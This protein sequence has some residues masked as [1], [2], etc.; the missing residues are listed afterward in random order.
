M[1]NR[2][3]LTDSLIDKLKPETSE[4][5]VYDDQLPG[6]ALRIQPSGVKSWTLCKRMGPRVIKKCLGHFPVIGTAEARKLALQA[7]TT[8]GTDSKLSKPAP[9][10]DLTCHEIVNAYLEGYCKDH[11]SDSNYKNGLQGW[12]KHGKDLAQIRIS[13]LTPMHV[14]NWVNRIGEVSESVANRRFNDFRAA[15]NRALKMKTVK[16]DQLYD[17]ENPCENVTVFDDES[18]DRYLSR[19]E[20]NRLLGVLEARPG[21]CTDA[22]LL[23]FATS[24]RKN[25]VL[26]M[27]WSE[28][29][30]HARTWT[31]PADKNKSGKKVVKAL[32]ELA[33]EVLERRRFKTK[34]SG[35]VFPSERSS[36]GYMTQLQH[37]WEEVRETA[38]LYHENPKL[39]VVLHDLR[40]TIASWLGQAGE[41][42]FVIQSIL[43]H[44]NVTT[45][46]IYTHMNRDTERDALNRVQARE[47]KRA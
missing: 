2:A 29:D 30:L 1:K 13:Q 5:L 36:T 43:E 32:S 7:L 27:E 3:K 44:G 42:A 47:A 28:I 17:G 31:I 4:K 15:V 10:A 22:I 41:S 11:T 14:Q 37:Y 19:E 6:L 45:S 18:R 20:W 9:S 34:G 40:H 35:Y 12:N 24:T 38:G 16:L 46:Q 25:C 21:D 39:C 8:L 23:L 33:L 26:S